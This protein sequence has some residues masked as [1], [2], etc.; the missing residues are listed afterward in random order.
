MAKA[1]AFF[2]HILYV[3]IDE[4]DTLLGD[5][6]KGGFADDVLKIMSTMTNRKAIEE[7]GKPN[8]QLVFTGATVDRNWEEKGRDT[9]RSCL[10][11]IRELAKIQ[12]NHELNI[13]KSDHL[14]ALAS[15]IQCEFVNATMLETKH[16]TLANILSEIET[17]QNI[18]QLDRVHTLVFCNSIASCRSTAYY[19]EKVVGSDT[20]VGS[21]HGGMPP[22]VRD[23]HWNEF[24]KN[25][26]SDY[27]HKILICTDIASRGLDFDQSVDNIV[28]FDLPRSFS[29]FVHRAGRTARGVGAT[30]K[31]SVIV[32]KSKSEKFIAEKLAREVHQASSSTKMETGFESKQKTPSRKVLSKFDRYSVRSRSRVVYGNALSQKHARHQKRKNARIKMI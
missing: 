32:A 9:S 3:A 15:G 19:L 27:K 23:E 30:G 31:V 18:K 14:K 10:K 28:M 16:P 29:D 7:G 5:R 17:L 12:G 26:D 25:M 4:A 2:G 11:K 21:L 6:E 1:E 24:L 13:V 8:A 20:F 22:Q